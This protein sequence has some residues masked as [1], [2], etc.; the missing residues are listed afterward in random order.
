MKKIFP[1]LCFSLFTIF[2]AQAQ[3]SETAHSA[4]FEEPQDGYSK[5][6]CLSNQHT[7]FVHFQLNGKVVFRLFDAGFKTIAEQQVKGSFDN[8]KNPNLVDLDDV[9]IL[10]LFENKAGVT[11]VISSVKKDD[12]IL[13]RMVFDKND[14]HLIADEQLQSVPRQKMEVV[15]VWNVY[16]KKDE[17]LDKLLMPVSCF[18]LLRHRDGKHYTLISY[19]SQNEAGDPNQDTRILQFDE[20]NQLVRETNLKVADNTMRRIGVLDASETDNNQLVLLVKGAGA[21]SPKSKTTIKAI[22]LAPVTFDES[23]TILENINFA[24]AK[25]LK[26]A[27][28][29]F[30]PATKQYLIFSTKE[31]MPDMKS[32][33]F[34]PEKNNEIIRPNV[35]KTIYK[36][37]ASQS[38][39]TLLSS[40]AL[41]SVASGKYHKQGTLSLLPCH[42]SF[43]PNGDYRVIYEEY[44]IRH[45]SYSSGKIPNAGGSG[46]KMGG[47]SGANSKSS[48]TKIHKGDIG[49]VEYHAD[50]TEKGAYYIPKDYLIFDKTELK[51]YAYLHG[52]VPEMKR[53][54]GLKS[55][56]YLENASTPMILFND[57]VADAERVEEGKKVKTIMGTEDCIGYFVSLSGD[58]EMPTRKPVFSGD[59]KRPVGIFSTSDYDPER[60]LLLT[61]KLDKAHPNKGVQVVG[62]KID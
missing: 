24:G 20:N 17:L 28:L 26:D 33:P 34:A 1:F 35:Y 6:L 48:S 41:S 19:N 30:N 42:V 47:S 39:T 22:Y 45:I 5:L 21:A 23:P 61:L 37:G 56:Y 59:E 27:R 12:I 3:F 57:E 16:A 38:Q 4:Y 52:A 25:N 13:T 49:I 62:Y 31:L 43:F 51:D 2:S 40:P 8:L 10:G 11:A 60:H 9:A 14:G 29:Y 53:G 55:F 36:P 50:N 46:I 58:E 7:A 54:L 18:K 15:M 32:K 44:Y